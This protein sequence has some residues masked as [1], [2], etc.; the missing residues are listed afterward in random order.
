MSVYIVFP[1]Y[2]YELGFGSF[3]SC[4]SDQFNAQCSVTY[5]NRIKVTPVGMQKIPA[6]LISISLFGVANPV[7]VA[8][9]SAYYVEIFDELNRLV[10]R[11][12]YANLEFY[13]LT[14][15]AN[16]PFIKFNNDQSIYMNEGTTF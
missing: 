14:F 9:I 6:G 8:W 13:S 12:T 15:T 5:N 3:V 1:Y 7:D 4:S 11:R 16:G 2:I 10:V